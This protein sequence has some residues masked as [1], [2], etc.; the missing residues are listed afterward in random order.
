[1][2]DQTGPSDGLEATQ[3]VDA[4]ALFDPTTTTLDRGA[5]VAGGRYRIDE[6]VGRGGMAEVYRATDTV[7]DRDVAVKVMHDGVRD[8]SAEFRFAEEAKVLGRLEH[9][10]LVTVHDAG[11]S[12]GRPYIV[13][14]LV[15]GSSLSEIMAERRIDPDEAS[16]IVAGVAEALCAVHEI[17][18]IHRDVKPANILI[19]AD[20]LPL[21]S[22][23]GIAR[24][25]SEVGQHT[26]TGTA[27]GTVSYLA[28]EQVG[29]GEATTA[30]DIYAL[31]LVLLELITGVKAFTGT[32]VEA[33]VARLVSPVE[34]P[35]WISPRLRDLIAQ[36]TALDPHDRPT[37]EEV[38]VTLRA[39][40]ATDPTDSPEAPPATS[41]R[42]SRGRSKH[43][44]PR[45]GRKRFAGVVFA[46][47]ALGL[48]VVRFV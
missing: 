40:A 26:A 37:A 9:P 15:D 27:I 18:V 19:D 8:E 32:L 16:A 3:Y 7:L 22:D 2:T 13:M 30:I 39:M 42:V 35:E 6:L 1:M 17:D 41:A 47:V 10:G 24:I 28:P 34:V 5:V 12:G 31:G 21:L 48:I 25:A 46:V 43:A 36:M 44:A 29:K 4:A 11:T 38:A 33:A 23:F 45:R 20:G 14:K